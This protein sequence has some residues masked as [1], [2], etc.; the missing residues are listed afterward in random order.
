MHCNLRTY[1]IRNMPVLL[2]H[3]KQ[4]NSHAKLAVK[5]LKVIANI[6]VRIKPYVGIV[7]RNS[8][9]DKQISDCEFSNQPTEPSHLCE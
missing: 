8:G 5:F 1:I 3:M 7:W 6:F 9:V 2:Y 4:A